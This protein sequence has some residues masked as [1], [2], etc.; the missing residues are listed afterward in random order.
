MAYWGASTELETLDDSCVLQ[1]TE[2]ANDAIL[3][4]TLNFNLAADG[5]NGIP[6]NAKSS[7]ACFACCC[8]K[9]DNTVPSFYYIYSC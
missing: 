1:A 8:L 2:D 4:I 3:I 5:N 7:K 6:I 9:T